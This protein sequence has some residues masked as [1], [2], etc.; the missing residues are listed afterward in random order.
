MDYENLEDWHWN[1]GASSHAIS[2]LIGG[3]EVDLPE[4]YLVFLKK[5]DG[6]EG[7]INGGYLIIWRVEDIVKLIAS[8][9]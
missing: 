3:I 9:R 4:D 5:H 6:G 8:M 7:F 2:G 1:D